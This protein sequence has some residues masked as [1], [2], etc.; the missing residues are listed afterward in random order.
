MVHLYSGEKDGFTLT[1][2][3]K[4]SGRDLDDLLEI[5]I[6]N[7]KEFDMLNNKGVFSGLLRAAM[8]GKLSSILGGPNCR[9]RSALRHYP[10]EGE[11]NCPRPVRAWNGE[12]HGVHDITPQELDLI[13]EDDV[14]LYRMV[15]LYV[16]ASY[17]RKAK[18]IDR[19]VVFALEQPASPKAYMPQC[20]SWWDTPQLG[21]SSR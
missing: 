19:S 14:L 4:Q 6:L 11:P 16:V 21:S 18:M 1:K 10:I 8:E 5:D 13:T 15:L 2:A 7:G 9:S 17:V 20:V 3:W 12:E